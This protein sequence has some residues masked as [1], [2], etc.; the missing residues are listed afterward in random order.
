V[1]HRFGQAGCSAPGGS[2]FDTNWIGWCFSVGGRPD[3]RA[4]G[5]ECGQARGKYRSLLRHKPISAATGVAGGNCAVIA[6]RA[7]NRAAHALAL[8]PRVCHQARRRAGDGFARCAP[9]H[10]MFVGLHLFALPRVISDFGANE[11]AIFQSTMHRLPAAVAGATVQPIHSDS[12][13]YARLALAVWRAKPEAHRQYDDWLF[14]NERVPSLDEARAYAGQ[15]V[16]TGKFD[17]EFDDPWVGKQIQTDIKIHRANWLAVDN[18]AMPQIVM[19][20]A[21]SSGEINSVEHL[22]ILLGQYLGV[23][24]AVKGM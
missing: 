22:Q 4:K 10:R 20:D 8:Q 12:C 17:A 3:T 9:R 21:V 11:P 1:E 15:L 16:G 7:N 18:S 14:A 19:G 2:F 24:L 6:P 23:H 5:T 13:E